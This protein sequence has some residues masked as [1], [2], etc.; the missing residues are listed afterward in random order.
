MSQFWKNL[1]AGT[2][3][4]ALLFCEVAPAQDQGDFIRR[5][6]A[7]GNGMID[8]EESQGRARGMLERMA[9]SNPR[10]NLSRPIPV[11]MLSRE[12]E[13]MRSGF[14]GGESGRGGDSGRGGGRGE[15]GGGNF[16][17][18]GFGG[19]R[20]QGGGRD[21]NNQQGN[22]RGGRGGRQ[23]GVDESGYPIPT[24]IEG[25]GND[26]NDT[27]VLGFGADQEVNYSG[28]PTTEDDKRRVERTL[29]QNDRNNDGVIEGEEIT[30]GRWDD[31]DPKVYDSNR[32]GR[33][34]RNE[35]EI[36]AAQKRVADEAAE[37]AEREQRTRD[38]EQRGERGGDRG[39]FPGGGF[40][41]GGDRG[42][43][44][45][46][47]GGG[48]FPG[49]GFPGGGFPGGGGGFPGGGGGPGMMRFGG[50]PGEAMG[51]GP[52]GGMTFS[53]G[54]GGGRGGRGGERGGGDRER[55]EER[56]EDGEENPRE[57]RGGFGGGRGQWGG[58]GEGQ[59]GGDGQDRMIGYLESAF[60][61]ADANQSNSLEKEEWGNLD[62]RTNPE[63]LD[64]DKN[65]L[66]TKQEYFEAVGERMGI[67]IDPARFAYK[68]N[69]PLTYRAKE[70]KEKYPDVPI[71]F[72]NEDKDGDGQITM[73]ERST[74]WT[75][76]RL[77]RWLKDDLNGD[78]V[79]TMKEAIASTQTAP[80]GIVMNVP[81]TAAANGN[82]AGQQ[83]GPGGG[84]AMSPSPRGEEGGA[85]RSRNEESAPKLDPEEAKELKASRGERWGQVGSATKEGSAAPSN[86][87]A[88][89]YDLPADLPATI[90]KEKA[91]KRAKF[92]AQ[93]DKDKN[94][95][96][97]DAE[98]GVNSDA[99]TDKDGK[100]S[101]KE[102]LIF[103]SL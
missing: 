61:R 38:R 94:G 100:V 90:D 27:P 28:I 6:D 29:R 13:R 17:G 25:F 54:E 18:G 98:I 65:G 71:W 40:S 8:P 87:A 9:Q 12:M 96:L 26:Y 102:Y 44:M 85:R 101:L 77:A 72:W 63:D 64:K 59:Q 83:F 34:T 51:G 5:M 60:A 89:S 52:G 7:N 2:F 32:D 21:G 41:G 42:S 68:H 14:G 86:G 47:F 49:G 73:A 70:T 103:K 35:L 15:G 48:G 74:T 11:E 91:G 23:N 33:L 16:G 39:G 92:F 75:D 3:G 46:M 57:G 31:G 84:M 78:G 10:I 50:A 4:A 76:D 93:E 82:P 56:N 99:D 30:N 80:T 95:F 43:R 58:D 36:R 66:I 88:P 24:L 19:G 69:G 62:R 55:G 67:K 53:F 20:Q 1:A 79:I 45:A 37:K 22:Q 97:N 81:K